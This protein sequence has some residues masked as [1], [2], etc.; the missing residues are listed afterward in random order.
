MLKYCNI[1]I[2]FILRQMESNFK[3]V[4]KYFQT[5]IPTY[6]NWYIKRNKK[7]ILSGKDH[8]KFLSAM[9]Y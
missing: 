5:Q 2:I 1:F 4:C 8:L 9:S 6:A 7:K 3:N